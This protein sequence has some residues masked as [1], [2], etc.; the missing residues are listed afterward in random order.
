[1]TSKTVTKEHV[2]KIAELSKLELTNEETEKFAEMFSETLQVI[3][4]LEE[5]D[6]SSVPETYQVTG[7]T[8]VFQ[9]KENK[10]TLTKEQVLK[11]AKEVIRD[12]IATDAVF[13]REY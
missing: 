9:A 12:L 11:N 13:D 10:A 7:L 1:M 2:K 6:T 5:L 3:D 8:N 4:V